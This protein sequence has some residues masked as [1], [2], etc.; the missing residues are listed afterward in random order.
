[1]VSAS[2]KS[3]QLPHGIDVESQVH[4]ECLVVL[5]CAVVLP[6]T[7]VI[8]QNIVSGFVSQRPELEEIFY[9]AIAGQTPI[10]LAHFF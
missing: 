7:L 1:M 4:F 5:G 6:S 9:R 2:Q 3:W 10:L 8:F